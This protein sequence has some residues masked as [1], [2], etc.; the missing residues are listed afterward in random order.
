MSAE[1]VK[2]P[3]GEGHLGRCSNVA[4]YPQYFDWRPR[5]LKEERLST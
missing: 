2:P 1:S 3:V 5:A 4:S